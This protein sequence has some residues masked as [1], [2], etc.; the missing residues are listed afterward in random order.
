MQA[1]SC[2]LDYYTKLSQW[3]LLFRYESC[4]ST[5]NRLLESRRHDARVAHNRAVAQYLLSN[6]T[7]TDEFRRSLHTVNMQVCVWVCGCVGGG[8]AYLAFL[9]TC[10]GDSLLLML[11]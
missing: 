3:L 10:K 8:D 6:L 9:L 4:L 1:P 2:V 11:V 5:L 7:F